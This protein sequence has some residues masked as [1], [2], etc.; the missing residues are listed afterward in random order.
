MTNAA[1]RAERLYLKAMQIREEHKPGR[2]API[3]WHLA[4]R[5]HTEAMIDL[6]CWFCDTDKWPGRLG[7]QADSFSPAGLYYRAF[8]LGNARAAQHLAMHCFN[9]RDMHGYR[10]WLRLGAKLG[11]GYAA[12]QVRQFET[13]LPHSLAGRLGRLRP[14][15]KRDETY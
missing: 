7:A 11:D 14:Y 3:L 10:R 4:M 6:A 9:S 2:W 12:N 5:R 8:S 15:H 13:R 1:D